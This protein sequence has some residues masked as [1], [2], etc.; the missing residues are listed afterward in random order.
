MKGD[1]DRS[2]YEIRSPKA[3]TVRESPEESRSW[4][5]FAVFGRRVHEAVEP[6]L[7]APNRRTDPRI[8]V[9]LLCAFTSIDPI[10]DPADGGLAYITSEEDR[11]INLSRRGACLESMAPPDVGTRLLFRLSLPD[12]SPVE[13]VGQ[14]RWCRA[15]REQ[16]SP[17]RARIGLEM[18]G[19]P[20]DTMGRYE[21]ALQAFARNTATSVAAA[22]G[23]R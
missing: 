4:R 21:R 9:D 14:V 2:P 11:V 5:R 3:D 15:R 20:P 12:Q 19:A 16:G 8:P 1:R 17:A 7:P 22:Q 18:L 10:R 23:L 6:T 13:F